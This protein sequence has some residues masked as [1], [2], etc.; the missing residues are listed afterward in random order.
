MNFDKF[1]NDALGN[2]REWSMRSKY[3]ALA[4]MLRDAGHEATAKMVAQWFTRKSIPGGWL[5]I[6]V[7]VAKSLGRELDLSTYYEEAE[8]TLG[9]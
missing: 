1:L 7:S 9:N 6:I 2:P 4:G 5:V 3:I 8:H